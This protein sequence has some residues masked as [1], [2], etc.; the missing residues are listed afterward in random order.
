MFKAT[1]E[2]SIITSM[3]VLVLF[4]LLNLNRCMYTGS[5]VYVADFEYFFS[6]WRVAL[7]ITWCCFLGIIKVYFS[8][9]KNFAF[10]QL[11][12]DTKFFFMNF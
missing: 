5:T 4:S 9:S 3:I 10:Y 12:F 2:D 1:S 11:K 8:V 6:P 7:L